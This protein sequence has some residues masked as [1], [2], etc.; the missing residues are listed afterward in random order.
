MRMTWGMELLMDTTLNLKQTDPQH[1]LVTRADEELA[2]AYEQITR[3][4][5]PIAR[6]DEQLSKLEHEAAGHHSDHRQTRM[7]KLRAAF[8]GNPRPPGA[9]AVRGFTR[10]IC[11]RRVSG[12]C[13]LGLSTIR[14]SL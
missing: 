5:E 9:P 14:Y 6:A 3:A 11:A 10:L 8:P 12:S 13:I 1:V 7:N 4:D 2:H